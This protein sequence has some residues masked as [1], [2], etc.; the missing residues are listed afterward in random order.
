MS[1]YR[2]FSVALRGDDGHIYGRPVYARSSAEARASAREITREEYGLPYS[3]ML[4]A[5]H[6]GEGAGGIVLDD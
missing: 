2:V 3:Y 6:T 1:D 4:A 5:Y